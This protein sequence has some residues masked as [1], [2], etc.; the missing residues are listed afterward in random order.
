MS[1]IGSDKFAT[2]SAANEMATVTEIRPRLKI[3]H[4]VTTL[5]FLKSHG[6]LRLI[7]LKFVFDKSTRTFVNANV[8]CRRMS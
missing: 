8:E 2:V 6:T 5:Q 3:T 1:S 7:K 4:L